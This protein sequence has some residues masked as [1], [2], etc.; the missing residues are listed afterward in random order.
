MNHSDAAACPVQ[1]LCRLHGIACP[2]VTGSNW[3][4]IKKRPFRGRAGVG[5]LADASQ[6]MFCLCSVY[7]NP[8]VGIKDF[9]SQ[10]KN[11]S[12]GFPGDTVYFYR[13]VSEISSI[14]EKRK[15]PR[16]RKP[17]LIDS[18][19]CFFYWIFSASSLCILLLFSSNEECTY[20][21]SVIFVE[22]CP[23]ISLR[24]FISN[25]TST[26]LVAKLWRRV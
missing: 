4:H 3:F 5:A 26:H 22:E 20:L 1:N 15:A 17:S 21:S 11:V 6:G 12:R 14:C 8:G 18:V 16:Y 19:F 2:A 25:P 10:L 13:K 23:R 24:L 7:R 9:P